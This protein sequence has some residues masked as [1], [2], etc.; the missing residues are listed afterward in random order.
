MKNLIKILILILICNS[1]IFS[2][3]WPKI[4]KHSSG[5]EVTFYQPQIESF[6]KVIL[7]SRAAIM[8]NTP[9]Q[10]DPIFGAVWVQAKVLTDRDTRLITLDEVVVTDA[11][12]PDQDSTKIEELKKFLS[13]EIPKWELDITIDQLIASLEDDKGTTKE[14]F[15]TDP[16]EIIHVTT[17]SV[18]ISIDGE[19]KFKKLEDT[20][21]ELVINTP[22]FIVKDNWEEM[23][24]LKG[25][26]LWY[27]SENIYDGYEFTKE[28]PDE[29]IEL[30][31]KKNP[32]E[33]K[34]INPDTIKVK[35]EIIVR[36]KPA[37]LIVTTGEPKLA[38]IEGTSLL[39]VENTD[40][41]ILFD[42]NSQSYFILISGRWFQSKSLE[43]PWSFIEPENLPADFAKIP[44][45]SDMSNVLANVPGTQESKD[46]ILDTQIPQTAKVDRN[47]KLEVDYDGEPKFEPLS[48]TDL[49]Y[50]TN[51]DKNVIRYNFKYYCC[52]NAVW[53]IADSPKG[54]WTVADQVPDKIYEMTP[55]SPVYNTKYV[56]VYDS[57]PEYVY[58]GYYPGYTGCYVYGG[59]VIY[60]TGYY[61]QPWYGAYY[62]PRPVTYGFSVHYNPYSGWSYGFGMSYG[63]PYGWMAFSYHSYPYYGGYWGAGGYHSGYHHGYYQGRRAG[64][65][66]GYHYAQNNPRINPYGNGNRN[67]YNRENRG[68]I[69]TTDRQRNNVSTMDRQR[70]N[71]STGD[72]QRNRVNTNKNDVFADKQGNVYKKDNNQWQSREG[73]NWSNVDQSRNKSNYERNQQDLNRQQVSR[74][75]G[76]Q[77]TQSYN[78]QRSGG[79]NRGGGRRR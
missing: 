58:T 20:D 73:N 30:I 15:K 76:N 27:K 38:S 14:N 6:D 13:E 62:Y 67:V 17:P 24:Y 71:V 7:Q 25:G 34:D 36:T 79:S 52:D 49:Y 44:S 75:R 40:S 18:L 59:T 31:L 63:G 50:A 39:F 46:A 22:F 55:D 74:D 64:F 47:T 45:D 12:F 8:I 3:E 41:D 19:A 48:T 35:P 77:R 11:K 9:K 69:N 2:E 72:V 16:P 78:Q 60:G 23:Y 29:L 66:A 42:I 51:T 68:N 57:T 4:I 37:E 21:F 33:Y 43:G 61:Y 1:V 65:Y 28:I 32:D 5:T 53:F 54:P 26:V 10:T 56:Y 70:N